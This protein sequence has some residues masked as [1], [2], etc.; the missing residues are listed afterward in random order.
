MMEMGRITINAK[1]VNMTI[2][3]MENMLETI[4]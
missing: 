2:L 4:Q 1:A 3:N